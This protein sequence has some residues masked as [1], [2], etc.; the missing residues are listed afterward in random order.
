M[1]AEDYF[2]ESYKVARDQFLAAAHSRGAELSFRAYPVRG[3]DNEELFVDVARIGKPEAKKILVVVSGTHGVEG[4]CG[5]ACQVAWLKKRGNAAGVTVYL[6]HALNPYGFAWHRRVNEENV[7][8]NRN[9]VNFDS[10]LPDNPEYREL[11]P[12]LNPRSLDNTT[13]GK[14][15]PALKGWFGSPEKLRAFKAATAKGQYEF[16]KGIIFGG[17]GATWSNEFV[18]D[19]LRTLPT[20]PEMG[21]LLDIH[22]GLGEAGA[23]EIF[24]EEREGKFERMKRWFHAQKVTTL[25]DFNS[26]GYTITGSLYQA[27]TKAD[28][29][30]PWHCTALEFGTRPIMDVLLALQAD[31]W[32]YCF[33]N[34]KNQLSAMVQGMMKE[35]F[36]VQTAQVQSQ[37]VSSALD[38]IEGAVGALS[39]VGD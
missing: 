5:S 24:T 37:V 7:D 1:S 8:L 30:S 36:L 31:N 12:L 39:A 15:D 11:E 34:R 10:A 35:A 3:P 28:T 2:A 25:G 13:L 16:P 17:R 9:F 29:D 33:A 27:F 23:L 21:I 19:F 14:L 32:L 18:R 6:I 4:F 26:L 38:V 20:F 22:T